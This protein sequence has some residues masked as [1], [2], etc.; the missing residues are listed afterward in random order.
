MFYK[1]ARLLCVWLVHLLFRMEIY[2]KENIP[3]GGGYILASNHRSNFD[4]IFVATGIKSQI[5]FMAKE[6]LFEKSAFLKRL[7]LAL[8]AFPVAR[9]RGDTGAL[10][11]AGDVVRSGGVLGMFL[12]GTRSKT[13]ELGRP[14]SGT[15]MLAYQTKADVLPCAIYFE[16][17]MHFRSRVVVRYGKLIRNGELGFHGET[18][19]P[20]EMKAASHQIMGEIAAL[21]EGVQ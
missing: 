21:L 12:E 10:E 6:E 2:G 4:P 14:K 16:N 9:G 1:I 15:A 3:A 17:P 11:W 18:L 5:F 20:H 19:S 13:G 8:G 7:F